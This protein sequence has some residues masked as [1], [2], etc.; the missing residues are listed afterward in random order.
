M[1]TIYQNCWGTG[2]GVRCLYA[3]DGWAIFGR[4]QQ[5]GDCAD[6]LLSSTTENNV[7][8]WIEVMSLEN[9]P[10]SVIHDIHGLLDWLGMVC[11]QPTRSH[12]E[13]LTTFFKTG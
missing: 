11:K 12:Y 9:K 8:P 1:W 2:W 10:E 3:C 5:G 13:S 7:V 4:L 6:R